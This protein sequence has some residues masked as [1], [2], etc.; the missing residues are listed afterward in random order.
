MES[1][2]QTAK[3]NGII[4]EGQA[5]IQP[6]INKWIGVFIITD[7][8]FTT[9]QNGDEPS[10]IVYEGPFKCGKECVGGTGKAKI[11]YSQPGGL[12]GKIKINVEG[13]DKPHLEKEVEPIKHSYN[14]NLPTNTSGI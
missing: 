2:T 12:K 3:I 4:V 7:A 13:I 1:P 11:I 10:I 8:L 6:G 9:I 5:H 14:E